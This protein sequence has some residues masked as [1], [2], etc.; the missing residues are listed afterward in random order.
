MTQPN[1]A[2]PTAYRL[3]GLKCDGC[4]ATVDAAV[5]AALPDAQVAVQLA[6]PQLVVTGAHGA[7]QVAAAVQAAGFTYEG[8]TG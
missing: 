4:V 2:L 3:G 1:P 7:D 5:R 8:P 6:D